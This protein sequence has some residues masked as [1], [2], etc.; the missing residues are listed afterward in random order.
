[1]AELHPIAS[2]KGRDRATENTVNIQT[3][4]NLRL[5]SEEQCCGLDEF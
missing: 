3:N 4:N 5:G 1:M 2:T